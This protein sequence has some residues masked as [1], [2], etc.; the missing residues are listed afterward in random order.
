MTSENLMKQ[1]LLPCPAESVE[2]SSGRG[3][4][5]L[6]E[7]AILR[8]LLKDYFIFLK[9]EDVWEETT[10]KRASDGQD[11]YW[12]IKKLGKRNVFWFNYWPNK[13]KSIL[14][15]ISQQ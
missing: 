5:T 7:A 13:G 1:F 14:G 8:Q 11:V 3:G 6:C 4:M 10:L 2:I 15:A 9:K 12:E